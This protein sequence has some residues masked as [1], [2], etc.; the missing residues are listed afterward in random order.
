MV[1]QNQRRKMGEM[2]VIKK[3]SFSDQR[4]IAIIFTCQVKEMK[5]RAINTKKLDLDNFES[6]EIRKF[7]KIKTKEWAS[8][9]IGEGENSDQMN[10]GIMELTEG[11]CGKVKRQVDSPRMRGKKEEVIKL[12]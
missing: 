1:K 12:R 7:Y 9:R 5:R 3:D 6:E 11:A 2:T 10:R 8:E 4:R